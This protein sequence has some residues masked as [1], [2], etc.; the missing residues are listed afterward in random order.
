MVIAGNQQGFVLIR[1]NGTGEGHSL[2]IQ[3]I[4]ANTVTSPDHSLNNNDY[5]I[6]SGALGSVGELVNGRVFQVMNATADTFNL[7][8]PI[9]AVTYSGLGVITRI[10]NP[11]IQTKQFPLA[12]ELARKTRI[13]AQQYL[14]TRTD[15]AQISLLI[16]LSQNSANPYNEGPF[17]PDLNAPNDGLVYTTVLYTCPESTNLGLTTWNSNLQT[18]TASQQSQI[19]HRVNTSLIGD[20]V[21]LGFT[22]SD[23]QMR[24]L[25]PTSQVYDITAISAPGYPTVITIGTRLSVGQLVL[26]ENV[27]GMIELND[28]YWCVIAANSTTATLDVDSTAFGVY[29]TGGTVTVVS[30]ENQF[31][32]IELCGFII[33]IQPSQL[34]V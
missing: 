6:I 20:T 12:W 3:N 32:E 13:G 29:T 24:S 25:N 17:Y 2:A 10:Y 33:D 4:L 19:W 26:I 8:P 28:L 11:L 31:A 15:N 9:A 27:E 21:Q 1:A 30:N 16:F 7:N 5:I 14:L 22:I 23:D 18:P 34:L